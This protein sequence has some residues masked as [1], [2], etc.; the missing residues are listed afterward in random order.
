MLAGGI[1]ITPFMSMLRHA[2][3]TRLP[4]PIRLLYS[5]RDT[6]NIPFYNELL[7]L[8]NQLPDFEV[9]FLASSGQSDTSRGIF[10]R[11]LDYQTL[12][13]ATGNAFE[14]YSFFICGP[15]N[16]MKN[17]A[18]ILEHEGVEPDYII[19]EAFSQSEGFS[20]KPKMGVPSLTY[21]LT[22]LGLLA[23]VGFFMA[24]DLVRYVPKIQATSAKLAPTVSTPT[25]TQ[26]DYGSYTDN[27]AT[28]QTSPSATTQ[29]QQST[30]AS[31]YAN[32]YQAPVSTVS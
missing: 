28:Q 22:A 27:S 1:G 31:S 2:A 9:A 4:M 26:D 23:G 32:T 17:A 16:Y 20:W 30:G 19:T 6:N 25:T 13:N 5:V 15:K 21:A 7:E 18:S 10:N 12:A 8:Q 29:T 11:R 3:S 14:E 24:L